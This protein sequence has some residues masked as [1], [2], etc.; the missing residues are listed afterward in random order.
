LS[1]EDLLGHSWITENAKTE[2]ASEAD[3][4]DAIMNIKN[5]AKGNKF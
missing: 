5:F 3:I 2:V 4:K 1:A